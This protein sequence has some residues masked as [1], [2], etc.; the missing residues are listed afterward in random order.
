MFLDAT[1]ENLEGNDPKTAQE[2]LNN[3]AYWDKFNLHLRCTTT[4]S[5]EYGIFG[6]SR[7]CFLP[8]PIRRKMLT[9]IDGHLPH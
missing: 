6:I 8:N 3:F 4:T 1:I 7:I 9:P 2:I 5:G